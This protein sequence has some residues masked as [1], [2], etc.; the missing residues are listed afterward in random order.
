MNFIFQILTSCSILWETI[1]IVFNLLI[2]GEDRPP[3]IPNE[4]SDS[5]A[6]NLNPDDPDDDEPIEVSEMKKK[7]KQKNATKSF[8][9]SKKND[10]L[11]E[12]IERMISL[13]EQKRADI[14]AMLAM[15]KT[16]GVDD[17][18]DMVNEILNSIH[19]FELGSVH[20]VLALEVFEDQSKRHSFVKMH[21]SSR[22]LWL[23]RAI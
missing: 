19:G 5:S 4:V 13:E 1:R 16:Q 10:N 9:R 22:L 20:N 11:G 15:K 12:A 8:K 6:V 7:K 18:I 21:K 23:N 2:Q 3:T 17:T 14:A